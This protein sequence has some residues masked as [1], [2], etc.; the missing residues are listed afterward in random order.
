MKLCLLR[1][2]SGREVSFCLV[3]VMLSTEGVPPFPSKVM[4]YSVGAGGASFSK[5]ALT[6]TLALGMVNLSSLMVTPPLTTC[7]SSKW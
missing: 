6:S 5:I 7:H 4:V 2:A 3:V 1:E